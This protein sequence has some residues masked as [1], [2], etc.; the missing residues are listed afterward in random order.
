MILPK[1][2]FDRPA[3]S[4]KGSTTL[5]WAWP[6]KLVYDRDRSKVPAEAS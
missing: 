6:T 1:L 2:S 5:F 3:H 4:S